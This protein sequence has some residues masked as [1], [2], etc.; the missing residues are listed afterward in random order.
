MKRLPLIFLVA[1]A[2]A[3]AASLAERITRL[4]DASPVS[5]AAFWGIQIVDLTSGDTLF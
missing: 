5:R 1:A 3:S 4:V 2:V